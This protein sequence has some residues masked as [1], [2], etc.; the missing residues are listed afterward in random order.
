MLSRTEI[1]GAEGTA[2]SPITIN[3][4]NLSIGEGS[5]AK[6]PLGSGNL[7]PLGEPSPTGHL[8][9]L[10]SAV[11]E[12]D[13]HL[14]HLDSAVFIPESPVEAPSQEIPD[15]AELLENSPVFAPE[16]DTPLREE[17]QFDP[18]AAQQAFQEWQS[19]KKSL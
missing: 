2:F 14:E 19:K 15:N 5:L 8:E 6:I 11:S 18:I 4:P 1:T 12:R 16:I 13:G 17:D 3:I 10:N 7:I 9:H